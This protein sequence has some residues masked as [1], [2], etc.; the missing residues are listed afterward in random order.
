MLVPGGEPTLC[1]ARRSVRSRDLG[2]TRQEVLPGAW[3]AA[4]FERPRDYLR[5]FPGEPLMTDDYEEAAVVIIIVGG[6]PLRGP[7]AIFTTDSGFGRYAK[8][9][10]LQLYEPRPL[11]R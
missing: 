7:W 4:A 9:F 6:P 8:Q 11:R 1:S 5:A 10:S 2:P 3:A